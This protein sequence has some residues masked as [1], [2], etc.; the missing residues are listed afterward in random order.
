MTTIMMAYMLL[1]GP[2]PRISAPLYTKVLGISIG[3]STSRELES[4]IGKGIVRVG[5]HSDSGRL[6]KFKE[7]KIRTDSFE[8]HGN[9][10]LIDLFDVES[11]KGK[12]GDCY[13]FDKYK[14]WVLESL[15]YGEKLSDCAK[16][17]RTAGLRIYPIHFKGFAGVDKAGHPIAA[18]YYGLQRKDRI[19]VTIN[20]EKYLRIYTLFIG[21]GKRVRDIMITMDTQR[22]AH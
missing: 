1:S 4:K 22:A 9:R 18:A 12:L 3:Q 11:W 10:F 20:G 2:L 19:R 8:R 17:L 21:G 14:P 5:G 7:C 15:V 13:P 16:E 6:W